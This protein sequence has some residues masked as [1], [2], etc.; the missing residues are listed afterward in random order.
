MTVLPISA[1]LATVTAF[2]LARRILSTG[3]FA[4]S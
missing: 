1:I 2:R 4:H 3:L